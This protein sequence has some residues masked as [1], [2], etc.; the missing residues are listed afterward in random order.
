MN[1][2]HF[3]GTEKTKKYQNTY[4]SSEIGFN[5]EVGKGILELSSKTSNWLLSPYFD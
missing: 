4:G 2:N 1:F 5:S 3:F